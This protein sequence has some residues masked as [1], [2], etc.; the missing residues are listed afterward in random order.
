[1]CESSL[2]DVNACMVSSDGEASLPP[3]LHSEPVVLMCMRKVPRRLADRWDCHSGPREQLI[4]CAV[5]TLVICE[6]E[7]VN[8]SLENRIWFDLYCSVC[9]CVFIVYMYIVYLYYF[10]L[11]LIFSLGVFLTGSP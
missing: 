9:V 5:L 3:V 6:R 8:K 10:K 11:K 2:H 1:M 7:M 4:H